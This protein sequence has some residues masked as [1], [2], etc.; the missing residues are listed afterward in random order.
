MFVSSTIIK[1]VPI[2]KR[3]FKTME[4]KSLPQPSGV[5]NCFNAFHQLTSPVGFSLTVI[6]ARSRIYANIGHGFSINFDVDL[7]DAIPPDLHSIPGRH[8]NF[9]KGFF[10][11]KIHNWQPP[12]IT[13]VRDMIWTAN[14]QISAPIIQTPSCVRFISSTL[15]QM[16]FCNQ[17]ELSSRIWYHLQAKW[18][19]S[20]PLPSIPGIRMSESTTSGWTSF[21]CSGL[22]KLRFINVKARR[23]RPSY[24]IYSICRS[25]VFMPIFS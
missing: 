21:S 20:Q 8:C 15:H 13:D 4:T 19:Q 17:A 2:V 23:S 14:R 12:W 11:D 22:R 18:L 1:K 5:H 9:P 10:Q 6:V 24:R 25:L 7:I 3:V 16:T